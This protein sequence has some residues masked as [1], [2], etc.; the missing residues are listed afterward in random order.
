M[1]N[2]IIVVI[3]VNMLAVCVSAWVN[4][5]QVKE[6]VIER[7]T[8]YYFGIVMLALMMIYSLLMCTYLYCIFEKLDQEAFKKR[9]GSAYS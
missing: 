3:Q 7:S 6:G 1:F 8:G 4:I 2:R 9:I 5:Y